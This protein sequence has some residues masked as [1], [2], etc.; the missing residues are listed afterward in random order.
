VGVA[1]M[2]GWSGEGYLK[3]AYLL[4]PPVFFMGVALTA[5]SNMGIRH[6]LLIYPF[7]ILAAAAGAWTLVRRHQAGA[8]VVAA[9]LALHV[10]SSLH[11]LPNYLAY[12]N[13][14]LGGT[15]QTYRTLS[16]SNVDWGQGIREARRYLEHRN[17]K[18]CWL[19]YF[20]TADPAY[21]HLPCK[22]LPDPFL[23]WWND[24]IQ[25]PPENYHGVVLITATEIAA[26]YWGTTTLNPYN[27]FL[28]AKPV[29]NIGGAVLVYEGDIDLRRASAIGHMYKAWDYI[30]AQNQEAAIQEALKAEEIVPEHPGPPFILGYILAQA[31]RTEA[32]RIQFEDC[33]KLAEADHPEFHSL[34]VAA[35]KAQLAILP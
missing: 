34:W 5:G 7:L 3:A 16:D 28:H 11:T 30:H 33:L 29:A 15:D 35:A 22:M 20:G 12:S 19:A 21:Y 31:K 6:V 13:E 26:P 4:I 17:I 25:V 27:Y 10:A 8:I 18:D 14:L 1:A 32:A 2:K 23:R 24:P 9:L